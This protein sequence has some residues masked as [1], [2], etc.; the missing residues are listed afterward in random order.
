MKHF[1]IEKNQHAVLY[2]RYCL[3]AGDFVKVGDSENIYGP[4]DRASGAEYRC[5]AQGTKG[6]SVLYSSDFRP[7]HF[8]PANTFITGC[9]ENNNNLSF[10]E[11]EAF[12]KKFWDT[13][14]K[15]V[16]LPNGWNKGM[17]WY[18]GIYYTPIEMQPQWYHIEERLKQKFPNAEIYRA[19]TDMVEVTIE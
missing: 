2:K 18:R 15:R 8:Y 5:L 1:I 7:G 6:K 13:Q 4:I 17:T 14:T 12:N 19:G 11:I 16:L 3:N 9:D 10:E